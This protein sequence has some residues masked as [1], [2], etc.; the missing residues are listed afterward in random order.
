M[1]VRLGRGET[2]AAVCAAAEFSRAE[3][4]AWWRTECVTRVP[5]SAGTIPATGLRGEV[6]IVRDGRGVPH[7]DAANHRD[8]FFGFGFA[9]AQDRLFQLD[10]LRRKARGRLAEILCAEGVESDILYR[11]VGVGRIAAA[12]WEMF[13]A[14]GREFVAAYSDG[15]NAVIEQNRGRW[16]IEFDLLDYEP[17]PWSPVD[18]LAIIGEFRWYLTGRFPVIAVPELVKRSLGDGPL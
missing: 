17:E 11:T 1:L 8:L 3:F 5:S 12:E 18:C 6:R 2:I 7:I 10:F 9:V 13:P 14:D 4:D 15:I 16:P